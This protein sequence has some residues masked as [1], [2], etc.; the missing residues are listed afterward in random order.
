MAY[1]ASLCP[2]SALSWECFPVM[3]L[4]TL[5]LNVAYDISLCPNRHGYILQKVW[6]CLVNVLCL[7]E[8]PN[9]TDWVCLFFLLLRHSA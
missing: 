6:V 7:L 1:D 8:K 5:A 3:L 4:S 9:R 2:D